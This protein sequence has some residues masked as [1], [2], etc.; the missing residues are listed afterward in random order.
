ML[1]LDIMDRSVILFILTI[2]LLINFSV[3]AYL[4]YKDRRKDKEEINEILNEI[5][6]LENEKNKKEK[7][8]EIKQD[9]KLEQNKKEVEEMLLKMQKDLEAK[10]EDVVSNFENE[11]EEKSII[12]YQELLKSVKEK[13]EIKATPVKIEEE[14]VKPHE[15][16]ILKIKEEDLENT[17]DLSRLNIKP[18]KVDLEELDNYSKSFKNTDFISPIFGKQN[19]TVKYPTVPKFNSLNDEL[20]DNLFNSYEELEDKKIDKVID[21][22]KLDE[23]IK[24]NDDFLAS[25]KEFRRSLDS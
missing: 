10:P 9:E 20:E 8:I 5:E 24:K 15:D 4:I 13:P 2:I 14:I 23:Q 16:E 21:T 11:Q 18:K 3:I 7:D 25:L 22:R 6:P 17:L 1:V 19:N 12:S